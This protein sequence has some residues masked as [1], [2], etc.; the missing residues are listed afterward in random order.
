MYFFI[1]PENRRKE[2]YNKTESK[3]HEGGVTYEKAL[4]R[5]YQRMC[6][7]RSVWRLGSSPGKGI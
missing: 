6:M 2:S 3:G 5:I 4:Y 7:M 1:K